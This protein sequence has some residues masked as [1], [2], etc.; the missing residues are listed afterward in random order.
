MARCGLR[1]AEA[2]VI[3][4]GMPNFFSM[5]AASSMTGRSESL[6]MTMPT[7]GAWPRRLRALRPMSVRKQAPF[8]LILP[9]AW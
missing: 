3:S 7:A 5:A 9:T 1:W 6:P 2:T 8:Q 4:K